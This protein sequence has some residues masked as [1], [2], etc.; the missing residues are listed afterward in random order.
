MSNETSG[1]PKWHPSIETVKMARWC[2]SKGEVSYHSR[3]RI[4]DL[5]HRF[6]TVDIVEGQDA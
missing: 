3:F 4:G 6:G 1:R 5:E 2:T